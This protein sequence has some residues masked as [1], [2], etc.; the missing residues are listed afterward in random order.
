MESP[1]PL[2]GRPHLT[3]GTLSVPRP[4]VD[5]QVDTPGVGQQTEFSRIS[6]GGDESAG[7]RRCM[8]AMCSQTGAVKREGL[9]VR[10]GAPSERWVPVV[11]LF[12]VASTP[13]GAG[14]TNHG[15]KARRLTGWAIRDAAG[16]VY[17]FPRFRLRPG[18]SVRLHTG[19]GRNTRRNLYWGSSWYIWNNTGDKATLKNRPGTRIDGVDVDTL[20]LFIARKQ[21]S[22]PA[23]PIAV[24][25]AG[26]GRTTSDRKEPRP[27]R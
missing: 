27:W 25:E 6:R 22:Q 21:V 4:L 18:S 10:Y 9:R 2:F 23:R 13:S 26:M 1:A 19:K 12:G 24:G 7:R 11:A 20:R 3:T 16:H 14:W 5:G 17:R 8:R 15:G